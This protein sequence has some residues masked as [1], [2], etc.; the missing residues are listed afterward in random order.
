MATQKRV[1]VL[2]GTIEGPDG[3]VAAGPG[4]LVNLPAA[5]AERLAELGIV[6]ILRELED[7]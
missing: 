1:K 7:L 3:F 6:E 2:R 4:E 5:E